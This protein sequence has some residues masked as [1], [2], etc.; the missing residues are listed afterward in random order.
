MQLRYIQRNTDYT[1]AFLNKSHLHDNIKINT[2]NQ[3]N[4]SMSD[5]SNT[6]M[7]ITIYIDKTSEGSVKCLA[8]LLRVGVYDFAFT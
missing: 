4:I 1:I 5:Y 8:L 2:E 6:I 3:S 7:Y